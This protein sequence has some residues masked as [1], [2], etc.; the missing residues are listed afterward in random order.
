MGAGGRNLRATHTRSSE[1]LV[2]GM[3]T[4]P[5]PPGP[6]TMSAA[7]ATRLS[8]IGCQGFAAA[9]A[10]PATS[11]AMKLEDRNATAVMGRSIGAALPAARD[12]MPQAGTRGAR[13]VGGTLHP[14]PLHVTEASNREIY[15]LIHASPSA[16]RPPPATHS[17]A[18]AGHGTDCSGTGRPAG[19]PMASRT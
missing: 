17:A 10:E 9:A 12:A 19:T 11:T 15:P 16:A 13:L 14:A 5:R 2:I 8:T 3:P 1:L 18:R 4:A 7:T 6:G